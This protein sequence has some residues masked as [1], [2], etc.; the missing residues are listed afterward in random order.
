MNRWTQ[1]LQKEGIEVAVASTAHRSSVCTACAY[2]LRPRYTQWGK[3]RSKVTSYSLALN[4][5]T[6]STS[7]S[8]LTRLK[9]LTH[10]GEYTLIT[11]NGTLRIAPSRSVGATHWPALIKTERARPAHME[12]L[13][14]A[15]E[16]ALIERQTV[17][18][19][20][21]DGLLLTFDGDA[22]RDVEARVGLNPLAHGHCVCA[23]SPL[24]PRATS[25]RC[26]G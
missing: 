18:P 3:K 4:H 5:W 10:V 24:D 9:H 22:C 13:P 1:A 7:R 11:K 17:R 23:H 25:W 12:R 15:L 20:C 21:L 26:T 16:V 2:G 14:T 8:S 19:V 6:G